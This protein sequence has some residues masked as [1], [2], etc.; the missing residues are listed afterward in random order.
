MSVS[1]YISFPKITLMPFLSF[2]WCWI[3]MD[4][5]KKYVFCRKI[6]SDPFSVTWPPLAHFQWS[7]PVLFLSLTLIYQT[8]PSTSE[9]VYTFK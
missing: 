4:N 2:E 6:S 5:K 8:S 1:I 7:K 9:Q 3:I